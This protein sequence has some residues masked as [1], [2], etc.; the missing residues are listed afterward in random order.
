MKDMSRLLNELV[1]V[2]E[3]L[4]TVYSSRL[5]SRQ[6]AFVG[7]GA[8]QPAFFLTDIIQP[9][10]TETGHIHVGDFCSMTGY[11]DFAL[12]VGRPYRRQFEAIKEEV[13]ANFAEQ[14]NA[15]LAAHRATGRV[16]HVGRERLAVEMH[17]EIAY[18]D[19]YDTYCGLKLVFQGAKRIKKQ[20]LD[21]WIEAGQSEEVIRIG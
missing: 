12:T 8:K 18:G 6:P 9:I 10:H 2:Y 15:I 11:Y 16:L 14:V 13:L 3:N 17:E 21:Q 5:E 20:Q 19:I 7:A 4:E 1:K